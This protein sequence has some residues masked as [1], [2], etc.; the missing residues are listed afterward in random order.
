MTGHRDTKGERKTG[1]TEDAEQPTPTIV[2]GRPPG[3]G[4]RSQGF[5]L[6]IEVL[7]KKASVDSEFR[8]ALLE[9]RSAAAA[10]IGLDLSPSEAA[11][12]D[13][14]PRSHIEKIIDRTTIP[15]EYR[16]GLPG[17]GCSSHV[18]PARHPRVSIGRAQGLRWSP[19]LHLRVRRR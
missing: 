1:L 15:D 6:G 12:L 3:N 10:D 19:G 11:T 2:G 9:K 13:A 4:N 7:L 18:G 5:P 8:K 14:V 17:H 16:R